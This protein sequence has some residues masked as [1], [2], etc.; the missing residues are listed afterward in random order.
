[1]LNVNVVDPPR[2]TGGIEVSNYLLQVDG[3]SGVSCIFL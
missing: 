3:G 1:M 2:D